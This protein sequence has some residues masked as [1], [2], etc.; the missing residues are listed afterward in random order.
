MLA[1]LRL[2][3]RSGFLSFYHIFVS[4]CYFML[5]SSYYPFHYL[6]PSYIVFVFEFV[7]FHLLYLP[8][9]FAKRLE[10][11]L[12]LSQFVVTYFL[13]PHIG[14]V[15]TFFLHLLICIA[16][17]LLVKFYCFLIF[18]VYI[19]DCLN[20]WNRTRICLRRSF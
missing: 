16:I 18:H 13:H 14:F 5:S 1:S 2:F 9:Y 10:I 19:V 6:S 12:S 17:D 8:L 15:I 4:F 11:I 7:P 3:C 20:R